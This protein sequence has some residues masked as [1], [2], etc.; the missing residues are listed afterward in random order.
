[1]ISINELKSELENLRYYATDEIVY[2][3]FNALSIFEK[4]EINPGQ[5]IYAICLEGPPGAGKTEFA[6]VYTKLSSKLLKSNVEMVDYQCDQTTGKSE[7]FEDINISAAIA[8]DAEHVNIPGKLVE[9]IQKVNQGKKVVLFIDEYDKAREETD[10]FLLQFL[11]SGKINATQHGDLE[12]KDEYKG[13]LQVF[14]CKNDFR[15]ELSGPLSRR[16]RILRLDYM[17]PE[18]FFKVANR[19]LVSESKEPVS[20]SLINLVSLMYRKAYSDKTIYNRLPSASEMLIAIEDANRLTK[21]AKAPQHIIYKTIIKNMFKS[22]DDIQA[23][24]GALSRT[25]NTEEHTLADLIK[26]MKES[27]SELTERDLLSL[28]A[29]KVLVKESEELR[30]KKQEMEELIEKYKSIFE[31]LEN[32][33]RKVIAEDIENFKLLNGEIELAHNPEDIVPSFNEDSMYVKRGKSA[34]GSTKS[35]WIDIASIDTLGISHHFLIDEIRK[36][37]SD[38]DIKIFEDGILLYEDEHTK[39]IVIKEVIDGCEKYRFLSDNI[40]IGANILGEISKFAK[41]ISETRLL[42]EKSKINVYEAKD[43]ASVSTVVY[44]Q[45]KLPY[46]EQKENIYL[47]E[48]DLTISA[49]I[50]KFSMYE[51]INIDSSIPQNLSNSLIRKKT[52]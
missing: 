18:I 51:N 41:L 52:Q 27:D 31:K 10:S 39:L 34:F 46:E 45:D 48:E 47:V 8:H 4:A 50:D 6:K 30:L 35:N 9:A 11:Q 15:E 36:Y 32:E 16:I 37:A 22:E 43:N 42:Q 1:M 21:Y 49:L 3:A 12:I 17:K 38:L 13:N 19:V 33:R 20:D 25:N 14:L 26:S 2:E 29:E 5:D 28:I 24:E 44:S 7:L 40:I 23:F